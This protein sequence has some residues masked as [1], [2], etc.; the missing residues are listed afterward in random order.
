MSFALNDMQFLHRAADGEG[1]VR[2]LQIISSLGM[3]GAE[4]WLMSLVEDAEV[5]LPA[6]DFLITSG[7]PGHFDERMLANGCRIHYLKFD[8][9]NVVGFAFGF[10]K[11]LKENHY[12]AIHD[13]QDL[14]AGWHFLFGL[15]H[16]PGVRA[17]HFHNPFYQV[18]ENYGVSP[19]R[20]IQ[21][22]IGR[23]L[24]GW[25]ATDLL[26][27][28]AELLAR[29][30]VTH[31]LAAGQVRALSC[32]INL[33]KWQ[34]DPAVSRESVL[35]ELELNQDTRIVLFVGRLDYSLDAAHPQNHKNSVFALQ[36]LAELVSMR[37]DVVLVMVGRNDYI[38]KD[39]EELAASMG[40]A[41]NLVLTG[42]RDDVPR[43][44]LAADRLLF[45]SRDEGLGMVAVEAQ[46][47][48]LSVL[49]SDAVPGECVVLDDKVTFLSL[50]KPAKEW[51]Q[52]LKRLITEAHDRSLGDEPE[53]Q[54]S[55]FNINVSADRLN[56]LYRHEH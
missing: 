46:A 11:I 45:P 14:L 18:R 53:W 34:G 4:T 47:A 20:K 35:D 48:G 50:D 44:M 5:D 55:G 23:S 42:V 27:T 21:L 22:A 37:T 29:Y 6:I 3:G 43:F 2:V 12:C 54:T 13:H 9:R 32:G 52:Q 25:L 36:V 39:F 26:G 51:A 17:A 1:E 15:G 10:R 40:V 28:S 31:L 33:E 16:L 30:Q 7:E 8:K 24:L 49:A 41:R 38:K 56:R 19:R